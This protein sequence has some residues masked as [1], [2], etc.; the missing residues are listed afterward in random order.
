MPFGDTAWLSVKYYYTCSVI[1]SINLLIYFPETCEI[2]F[3]KIFSHLS[4]IRIWAT[5]SLHLAHNKNSTVRFYDNNRYDTFSLNWH[6][7]ASIKGV[8][9]AEHFTSDGAAV[10]VTSSNTSLADP[11]NLRVST[12]IQASRL[13]W[14]MTFRPRD[15]S[16]LLEVEGPNS[17]MSAVTSEREPRNNRTTKVEPSYRSIWTSMSPNVT[18]ALWRPAVWLEFGSTEPTSESAEADRTNEMTAQDGSPSLH[19]EPMMLDPVTPEHEIVRFR[20]EHTER[21]AYLSHSCF[22]DMRKST[23]GNKHHWSDER[24]HRIQGGLRI[25]VFY[26]TRSSLL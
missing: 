10:R 3:R 14:D 5:A 1:K 13:E 24:I 19:T 18:V 12:L 11:P 9:V 23:V 20:R 15:Q 2:I 16:S 25:D 6:T 17:I 22:S 21:V 8:R 26:C 7:V 4:S